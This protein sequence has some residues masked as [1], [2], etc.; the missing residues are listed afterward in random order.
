MG[1][2]SERDE[3]FV[4]FVTARS[5]RL[6]RIARMLCGD[7]EL[8]NDIVQTA[9]EKTYVRWD[10]IELDPFSYVRQ[11]IVNQHV[12][13][14]RR[15]WREQAIGRDSE[16]DALDGSYVQD[17]SLGVVRRE[18]LNTALATLT[19]RERAVLVLRF[20]EDQTEAETAAV[21]GVAV[22]TVKST[23]ARAL[24]KLRQTPSLAEAEA[25]KKGRT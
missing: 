23:A 8:A 13:W 16:L 14:L 7:P 10:R 5:A 11:A 4:A 25:R 2:R 24:R 15:T 20:I 21:L 3:E 18:L 17:P 12:S 22:G 6:V 1:R 19:R 9:L